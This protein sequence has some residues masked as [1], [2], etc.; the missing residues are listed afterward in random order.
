LCDQWK[1]ILSFEMVEGE[2]KWCT[3]NHVKKER[4]SHYARVYWY[5][6]KMIGGENLWGNVQLRYIEKKPET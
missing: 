2:T 5:S 6:H 1:E 4:D 3:K